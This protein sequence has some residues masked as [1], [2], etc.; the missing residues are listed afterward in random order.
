MDTELSAISGRI[1]HAADVD[2]D[3]ANPDYFT[4]FVHLSGIGANTYTK[5][6]MANLAA[7]AYHLDETE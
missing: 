1:L 6:L 5:A 4:D 3:D 2:F 7:E